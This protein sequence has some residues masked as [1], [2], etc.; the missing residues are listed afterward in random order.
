[1]ISIKNLTVTCGKAQSLLAK[2]R[3]LDGVSF[4][5]EQGHTFGLVG[6]SGSGKS[7]ILKCLLGLIKPKFGEILLDQK[8]PK[9]FI[10]YNHI[11][12]LPKQPS[13]PSYMTV[14]EVLTFYSKLLKFNCDNREKLLN[15]ILEKVYLTHS[16]TLLVKECSMGIIRRL[17]IAQAILHS[18][19]ILLLDEPMYSLDP[20][21]RNHIFKILTELKQV[22]TTILFC[23]HNLNDIQALCDEIGIIEQGKIIKQGTIQEVMPNTIAGIELVIEIP[24]N[25]KLKEIELMISILDISKDQLTLFVPELQELHKVLYFMHTNSIEVRAIKTIRQSLEDYFLRLIPDD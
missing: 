20:V 18:P 13:Y 21:G 3:I 16:K 23:S 15:N 2:T 19:K 8:S 4:N 10:K 17:G 14:L 11:G 1:M 9:K 6:R 12:Y 5:I 25:K 22:G 24:K 7:F